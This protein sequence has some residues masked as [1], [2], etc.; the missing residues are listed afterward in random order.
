M[1]TVVRAR[2]RA[3]GGRLVAI[4]RLPGGGG[5]DLV[6][7]LRREGEVLAALDHPHI[8]RVFE[9]VADGEGLA[10]VMQ[11]A[12][13]GSLAEL[14]R[15]A[16]ARSPAETVGV[17]AP[18]AD[19]LASAHRRGVLHRDVKPGNILFT[20][21]GE[22]L[23]S[24]FGTARWV[25]EGSVTAPGAAWLTAEYLDP[26]VAEGGKPDARSDVY[27][28]AVVC[29][30]LLTGRRPFAGSGPLAALR[31]ADQGGATP[32]ATLA[33]DVPP[34][35]AA[36][37]E[38]ALARRPDDRFHS[39]DQ[40]ATALR[41]GLGQHPDLVECHQITFSLSRNATIFSW[42]SPSSTTFSPAWRSSAATTSVISWEME[43]SPSMPSSLTLSSSTG[44][45]LAAMIP[46]NEG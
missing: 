41:A 6:A 34:G 16:G 26:E 7:R 32:L 18:V 45:P 28:L 33:P 36:A 21:D 23:L 11:Y 13:G 9:L 30:E 27:S 40:F 37:I 8:V 39:A 12:A 14:L 29:Y 4:K 2:Q 43:S 20:A 35:L 17:A 24:D 31:A 1:G 22:P 46:L 25:A 5:A 42:A 44:L 38:R 15:D 3:S 10:I 19:A